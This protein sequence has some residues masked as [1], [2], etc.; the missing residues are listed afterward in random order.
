VP[1]TP[2]PRWCQDQEASDDARQSCKPGPLRKCRRRPPTS[3]QFEPTFSKD[4][5]GTE[6]HPSGLQINWANL[7]D[8]LA[9]IDPPTLIGL[10][11]DAGDINAR[12][13]HVEAVLGAVTSYVKAVVGDTRYHAACRIDDETGF[14]EDAASN[15]V[16]A[17]REAANREAEDSTDPA[18]WLKARQAEVAR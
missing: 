16:G 5:A 10:K 17:L 8:N 4:L 18:A 2:R 12:A 7:L 9:A 6:R 1:I 15:V 3:A 11:A 13:G 14:L